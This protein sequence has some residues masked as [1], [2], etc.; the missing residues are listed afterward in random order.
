VTVIPA[1]SRISSFHSC[2]ARVR[3]CLH[4]LAACWTCVCAPIMPRPPRCHGCA[5]TV[6]ESLREGNLFYTRPEGDDT[7]RVPFA[8]AAETSCLALALPK[9]STE[10]TIAFDLTSQDGRRRLHL[11]P[12]PAR[13]LTL[14]LH[15]FPEYGDHTVQV[16]CEFEPGDSF[17]ALPP[18]G[19]C[20]GWRTQ[21][22]D[23]TGHSP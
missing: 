6:R 8:F 17:A 21:D 5:N 9:D 15:S 23:V 7:I 19:C 13:S 4:C 2:V 20:K 1:E 12:M 3:Q 11:G 16:E 22:S 18:G 10:G 14:G